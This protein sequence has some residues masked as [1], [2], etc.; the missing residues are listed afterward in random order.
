[1]KGDV[2]V[3][4]GEFAGHGLDAQDEALEAGVGRWEFQTRDERFAAGRERGLCRGDFLF[5]TGAHVDEAERGFTRNAGRTQLGR[6][7]DAVPRVNEWRDGD[8]FED[9]IAGV[10]LPDDEGTDGR[11]QFRRRAREAFAAGLDAIGD[12]ED[13]GERLRRGLRRFADERTGEVLRWRRR[14]G[15]RA[16][17]CGFA[18]VAE[19]DGELIFETAEQA[20]LRERLLDGGKPRGAAIRQAH[21]GRVVHEQQQFRALRAEDIDR[22]HRAAD[23]REEQDE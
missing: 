20:A 8:V 21:A 6:D 5:R 10:R 18:G 23:E 7:E 13:V 2:V 19:A 22:A 9:D 17:G 1:M 4:R 12:E 14:V 11:G 16:R 15:R 3:Q